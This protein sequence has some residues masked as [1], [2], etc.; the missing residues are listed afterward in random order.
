MAPDG[1]FKNN[2]CRV[3]TARK[4]YFLSRPNDIIKRP[5]RVSRVPKVVRRFLF[6]TVRLGARVPREVVGAT[7]FKKRTVKITANLP[8]YSIV[9]HVG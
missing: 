4:L 8:A 5:R 1:V 3:V 9:D 2:L 6:K 7:D